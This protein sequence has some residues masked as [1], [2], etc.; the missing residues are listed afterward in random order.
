ML[1]VI[2]FLIKNERCEVMENKFFAVISRLKYINR[3]SLMR[4]TINENLSE[5]SLETAFIAHALATLRNKRFGGNVNAERCALLAMYHDVTEIITGDLPTPVKYYNKE[6]K[7]AYNE[8]EDNAKKQMLT[9]L[10]EDIR[11]EYEP[12]FSR[13]QEEVELWDIVK[14]ADKISALI[15]C[16]E[17][18]QMGNNDFASAEK[19]TYNAVKALNLPEADMFL[20][21]FMPSYQLTLDEQA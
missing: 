7:S 11:D 16:V 5:H 21:E 12:L 14:A 2:F 10:P 13:T 18:R 1:P 9:Y 15:K 4:N 6:I 3:W 19:S 17:E 20:E 8:I